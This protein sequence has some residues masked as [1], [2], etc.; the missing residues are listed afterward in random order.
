ML[1]NDKWKKRCDD[2]T[3]VGTSQSRMKLR[4]LGRHTRSTNYCT[5]R[6]LYLYVRRTDSEDGQARRKRI[7]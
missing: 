5:G 1:G 4:E 3:Y 7:S 2:G 6:G